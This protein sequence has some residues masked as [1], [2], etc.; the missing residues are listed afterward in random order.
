MENKNTKLKIWDSKIRKKNKKRRW[1]A[2]NMV[3]EGEREGR[4]EGRKKTQRM[5]LQQRTYD[6]SKTK[7]AMANARILGT[8]HRV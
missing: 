3:Q 2:R 6:D 5:V 7:A 4:Q 1:T 8:S